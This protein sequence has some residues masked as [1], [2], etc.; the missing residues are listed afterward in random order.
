MPSKDILLLFN[1]KVHSYMV[2]RLLYS[3]LG[4]FLFLTYI[5]SELGNVQYSYCDVPEKLYT[6]APSWILHS[7]Q[8]FKN[9][10]FSCNGTFF[11]GHILI[12]LVAF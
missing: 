7:F 6:L 5:E 3:T 2:Y 12:D 8:A 4:V 10:G 11:V 1:F 9:I